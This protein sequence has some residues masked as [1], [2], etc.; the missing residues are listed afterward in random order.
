MANSFHYIKDKPALL[1]KLKN[2]LKPEGK[3]IIEYDTMKSNPW[4]PYP[5]D[6]L[7]L[8][9]LFI[10]MDFKNEHKIGVRRSLYRS[11]NIYVCYIAKEIL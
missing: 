1:L 3:F 5:I 9:E 8:R 2:Y 11:E 4:V 10:N 6:Y 7:R